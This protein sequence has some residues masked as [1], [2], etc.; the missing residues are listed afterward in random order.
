MKFSNFLSVAG[1]LLV[2]LVWPLVCLANDDIQQWNAV[3]MTS[4]ADDNGKLMLWFDGHVRIVDDASELG[5]TIIRPGIGY[6]VGEKTTLWLGY[7][8]VTLHPGENID[9]DRIWQ[10]VTFPVGNFFGG[11]VSGRTRLEQRFREGDSGTGVR[12]RQ[13]FRWSRPL[14]DSKYSVVAWDEL[15]IGLNNTEGGL[16]DGVDQNRAFVGLAWQ[17]ERRIRAEIGYLNNYIV[18]SGADQL[19]HILSLTLF[20]KP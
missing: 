6:R 1:L 17:P 9:E 7:A 5:T 15:F 20:L 8:R 12:L 13:F 2:S 3:A 18:R 4:P 14:A 19:N 11:A 16:R 10:Q